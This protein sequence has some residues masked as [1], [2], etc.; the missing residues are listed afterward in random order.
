MTQIESARKNIITKEMQAIAKAEGVSAEFVRNGIAKGTI[1]ICKNKLRKYNPKFQPK[2]I[3][4]GLKIKVNANIGTSPM[5][6]NLSYERQKLLTSIKYGAD[7][8]MDLST[9]GDI[10]KIRRM[11]ISNSTIPVGTV[12]IYGLICEIS[13]K[14]KKFID[15]NIEQIFAEIEKQL[16]DGIDFIT[17]HCGLTLKAIE[18]LKKNKRLVGIVSRGGAFLAEWMSHHKKEN[19]LYEN[20]DDL[21]KLAK[22]YDAVISLGD[23]LRPGCIADNTDAAQIEELK[24]LGK[25]QAYALKRDVQTIIEGPGHVPL[26]Q[27]EKNIKLQKKYCHNAPFYVLGPLT[28]DIAPGYDHI[29]SA[30]GG[31][32]AGYFGA[33]F[34]C[35][36]TPAEHLSLPDIDDVKNGV[37]ASKIAAHSAEIARGYKSSLKIDYE[38]SKARKNFDWKKQKALSIDPYEFEK[39]LSAKGKD[40]CSMCGEFCA[41]KRKI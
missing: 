24:T 16:A 33:D 8:V 23:G 41:M 13:R 20:Y 15:V 18:I 4:G 7:A 10:S 29:T 34:L 28:T 32:L 31:A 36:V 30:I 37:I 14:K 12:P 25:L 2:G 40:V 11:V 39:R 1:V 6:C 22:K 21:L 17:V 38:L 5:N 35:Y 26:N 3:G 9:G 27:I 19:P